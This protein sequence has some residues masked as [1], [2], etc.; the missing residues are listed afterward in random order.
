MSTC[1]VLEGGALR[2][3][4]TTGVLA[5]LYENKLDV[6][7]IIG[8]SAG[9][10]FGVN[11]FANQPYRA[12]E[13]N[14]KFCNDK[15]YMSVRSLILTGNV[16]NKKFAYYR[17]TKKE[18]PFD[19]DTFIKNNKDFYAVATSMDTGCAEYF[20]IDRP[21]DQLEELRATSAMP[22]LSRL[23]K[24]NGKK[25]LDGAIADSIPVQKAM[26]LGYDKIVVVLT[27]P[28]DF[29]KNDLTDK[30][31]KKFKKKYKKYP[32]FLEQCLNRPERYNKLLDDIKKLE[33]DKKIFVMRPSKKISI[34]PI[35]KTKE[36]LQD[37]YDLG[38]NDMKKRYKE[39][40]NY[41][42]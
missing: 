11:Y 3:L 15:R 14:L 21:I 34:N 31:I 36:E 23:I 42:K 29:K 4:Y 8:V 35:K 16:V 18:Y 28:I 10:L 5:Y 22:L 26:E 37:A 33:K 6:D 12:L 19:Q 7:C 20:K 24:V 39:L 27:Q 2:G 38:Y 13:Y 41:L 40:N 9:A 32:N 30:E 17:V 1:L 25:Y